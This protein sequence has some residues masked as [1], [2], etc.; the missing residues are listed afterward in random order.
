M[1]RKYFKQMEQEKARKS[2][3][4]YINIVLVFMAKWNKNT[5]KLSAII[6][7]SKTRNEDCTLLFTQ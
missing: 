2:K 7:T 4:R 5:I 6:F 3:T 1:S